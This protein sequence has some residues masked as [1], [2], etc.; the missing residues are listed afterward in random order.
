MADNPTVQTI[1]ETGQA[2]ESIRILKSVS[3]LIE[4]MGIEVTTV[5]PEHPIPA[6]WTHVQYRI[7]LHPNGEACPHGTCDTATLTTVRR[8]EEGHVG[9]WAWFGGHHCLVGWRRTGPSNA[10]K[11]LEERAEILQEDVHHEAALHE[12]TKA[13]LNHNIAA[14]KRLITERD[15]ALKLIDWWVETK[16]ALMP[17]VRRLAWAAGIGWGTAVALTVALLIAGVTG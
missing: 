10:E 7:P 12:I 13:D 5:T 11:A 3:T 17:N 4:S 1:P 9:D 16:T 14:V 8:D 2:H 15:R 6:H